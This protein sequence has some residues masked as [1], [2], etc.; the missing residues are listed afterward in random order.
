MSHKIDFS[1]LNIRR[2]REDDAIM[3]FD[4]GDLDL[5]DFLKKESSLYKTHLL[6]V[7]YVVVDKNRP[8]E[9]LAFCSMANDKVA[10]GDFAN[11]TEF[12]RFRKKRGFPQSKRLKSYPAVK[13]CRLGVDVK[14]RYLHLGSF[15]LNFMR[16]YFTDDNKSGCRFMTV[17][18]YIDAIP[19]YEKNGFRKLREKNEGDP[20]TR[21]LFCDLNV[22]A[23]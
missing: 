2:L 20:H 4:C 13:L 18:A 15:L 8:S 23:A 17:D 22:V 7:S 10:L 16:G 19:F 1:S 12:N 14:Y 11:N 3:N 21:L 5:N 9:I 6:A